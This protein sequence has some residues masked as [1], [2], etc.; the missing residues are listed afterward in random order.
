MMSTNQSEVRDADGVASSLQTHPPVLDDVARARMERRLMSAVRRGE[1]AVPAPRSALRRAGPVLFLGG[2]AA[3]AAALFFLYSPASP[4]EA[5]MELHTVG[6][7]IQRGTIEQGSLLRTGPDEVADL[8]I[9][10]SRVHLEPSTELRID[11]LTGGRM[12]FVLR[13]GEIRVEFHPRAPGEES[14]S[15]RTARATVRVVGTVFRV[16]ATDGFTEVSVSEGR[17]RV[18]PEGAGRA[19]SV[20]VGEST[21]V[22]D[23]V[24]AHAV[25]A[26]ERAPAEPVEA[27]AAPAEP[28]VAGRSV[29]TASASQHPRARPSGRG[30][31]P[32]S[33]PLPPTEQLA[34]ARALL[35]QGEPEQAE[36]LLRVAASASDASAS[37]R[38]DAYTLLGDLMQRRGALRSAAQAYRSAEGQGAG[39]LSHLA[40]YALARLQD[41]RMHDRDAARASYQRFVEVEPDG[42]LAGAARRAICRLDGPACLEAIR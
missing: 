15:V 11:A 23:E 19:R 32:S 33:S 37:V 24:A 28:N 36:A 29:E 40:I 6:A 3:A 9:E 42:P 34:L 20:G 21:R 25:S 16:R 17:V 35:R 12:A 26:G 13:S 5:R 10:D 22:G 41:R 27:A 18:E 8:H 30:S 2:L 7:T 1:P 31:R 4:R 14:M 39:Q 38:A